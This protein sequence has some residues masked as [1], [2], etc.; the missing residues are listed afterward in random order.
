M[1][2]TESS[3]ISRIAAAL[4]ASASGAL[5]Q[6]PISA[7]TYSQNFD[8]VLAGAATTLPAGWS[9]TSNATTPATLATSDSVWAGTA[10]NTAYNAA[11][12][13]DI[14]QPGDSSSDRGLSLYATGVNETRFIGANFLNSTGGVITDLA[15]TYDAV[16]YGA[17]YDSASSNKRWDGLFLRLDPGTGTFSPRNTAYESTFVSANLTFASAGGDPW[18]APGNGWA[19]AAMFGANPHKKT[20]TANLTGLAIQ[21]GA[22]FRLRWTSYDDSYTRP[23]IP[24]SPAGLVI[25]EHRHLNIGVDNLSITPTFTP[26]ASPP[27]DPSGEFASALN[28]SKIIVYWTDNSSDETGFRIERATT[29]GGPWTTAGSVVTNT[30]TF[31]DTG[32][33]PLTNYFYRIIALNGAGQ[34]APT[35]ETQATTLAP[36]PGAV[37]FVNYSYD[38]AENTP[39]GT[40]TLTVERV[41]DTVGAVS[42]SFATSD[43]IATAGEN[44][45]T[46]TTGSLSWAS[47]EQGV[48]SFTIAINNDSLIENNEDF[49]VSLTTTTGGLALENPDLVSVN[50]LNDDLAGQ[51]RFSVASLDVSE[52][53]GTASLLVQRVAGAVGPVTVDFSTADGVATADA[54]YTATSGTLEWPNGDSSSKTITIP[55]LNDATLERAETFSVNLSNASSPATLT[56]PVSCVVN[57]LD[58]ETGFVLLDNFNGAVIDSGVPLWTQNPAGIDVQ[59]IARPDPANPA[60]TVGGVKRL[61]S[62]NARAWYL[63]LGGDAV[64]QGSS[65]TLFARVRLAGGALADRFNLGIGLSDEVTPTNNFGHFEAQATAINSSNTAAVPLLIRNGANSPAPANLNRDQ[66]YHLW[67]VVNNQTDTY[68]VYLK[69]TSGPA[70]NGDRIASGFAFRNGT[71]TNPLRHVLLVLGQSTTN[72]PEIFVDD[73]HLDRIAP[74][75]ANPLES[76]LS[77]FG[78]WQLAAFPVGATAAQREPNADYELDGVSNLLE[79]A[80]GTN[81]AAPSLMPASSVVTESSNRY[82]QI[83]WT[84]PDDRDD[85]TTVGEGA[86][87]LSAAAWSSSPA[88]VSTTI[89]PSGAGLET[90][91]IR[92]LEPVGTS[93]HRFLRA[94]VILPP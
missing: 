32:L 16:L 12:Q 19:T 23:T 42:V 24:A 3:P 37:R 80:L 27:A 34:S 20:V 64:A 6:I 81:P 72:N 60:N 87:D 46:S 14:T 59:F 49:F 83:Q 53:G 65:A 61:D 41:N 74:N 88:V 43:N 31:T 47:G 79:Y 84:R 92:L 68:D 13:S 10:N 82:L 15:I 93:S 35:A 75:L 5:C 51:L 29:S 73:L 70:T 66:W 1:K 69:S 40:V 62:N 54:D 9:V 36:D 17:R 50:I 56:T 52:S 89:T 77:G 71:A 48:K 26:P 86:P 25:A 76:G 28:S 58:N 55:I 45:Y 85:V 18:T 38:V 90:V 78:V 22:A 63:P 21:P 7:G 2:T 4:L 33:T 30:F 57:I 39:S 67:F 11:L 8:A 44:D 91:T 94:R